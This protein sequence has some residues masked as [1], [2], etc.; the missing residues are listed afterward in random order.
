MSKRAS[1]NPPITLL[2][3]D[4]RLDSTERSITALQVELHKLPRLTELDR[5]F[6]G[7]I[8]TRLTKLETALPTEADAEAASKPWNTQQELAALRRERN[9][10]R[11][12]RDEALGNVDKM[13]IEHD[14]AV[15]CRDALKIELEQSEQVNAKLRDRLQK[16]IDRFK[17]IKNSVVSPL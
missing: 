16:A 2:T 11:K 15:R 13:R 8:F 14:H 6:L 10:A 1:G 7:E 9:E 12:E 3:L 17:L 4:K 5:N